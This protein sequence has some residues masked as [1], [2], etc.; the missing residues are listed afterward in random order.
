MAEV[1]DNADERD[2]TTGKSEGEDVPNVVPRHPGSRIIAGKDR[3]LGIAI[4]SD[5]RYGIF[6]FAGEPLWQP[7][8][9]PYG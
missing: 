1:K 3:L 2:H 6:A 5:W 4:V 9:L 7:Y 8:H